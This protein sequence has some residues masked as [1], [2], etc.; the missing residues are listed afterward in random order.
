MTDR[1]FRYGQ[2]LFESIAVRNGKALLRNAHLA[3]LVA[4]ARR[5]GFPFPPGLRGDLAKAVADIAARVPGDGMMR[6]YLTAGSGSPA[7]PVTSP[8]CYIT[9]EKTPFPG[10]SA[11][12]KGYRLTLLDQPV[13]GEGWGEKNGNYAIHLAALSAARSTGADEGIVLDAKGRVVSCAMGNLLAWLPTRSGTVL[14][15]P[16]SALGARE[17]SVLG[18][19]AKRHPVTFRAMRRADLRRVTA[20]AVTNSR[21]GVMPVS[22]L[23]GR[24]LADIAPSLDLARHYMRLHG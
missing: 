15:S 7:A 8:E 23:N 24:P 9:W 17:G 10:V 1:G 20:L 13:A 18:W 4:A 6:I 14:C 21:L 19:V 5:T 12:E 22:S 11:I 2:H 3:L 16:G